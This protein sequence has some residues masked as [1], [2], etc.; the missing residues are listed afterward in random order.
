MP[1]T[2]NAVWARNSWAVHFFWAWECR[3][4]L[5]EYA[6]YCHSRSNWLWPS[7]DVLFC[8]GE[9]CLSFTGSYTYVS[10][11]TKV[12]ILSL[13]HCKQLARSSYL[14]VRSLPS[15]LTLSTAFLPLPLTGGE[16]TNRPHFWQYV[17]I[18]SGD[19]GLLG[20]VCYRIICSKAVE[21]QKQS[22]HQH[23]LTGP[24]YML[25]DLRHG[26]Y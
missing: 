1:H 13:G 2:S 20:P 25:C 22:S 17:F 24:C 9:G 3:S 21:W 23:V 16:S 8:R 7:K 18:F 15:D 12:I 4:L 26:L 5:T 6:R 19:R 11:F 10:L 14:G